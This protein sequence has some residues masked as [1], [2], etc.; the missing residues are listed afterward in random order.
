MVT[1]GDGMTDPTND[2]T[3]SGTGGIFDGDSKP[4]IP[5]TTPSII[6]KQLKKI[7]QSENQITLKLAAMQ[8]KQSFEEKNLLSNF[9]SYLF[10]NILED[11]EK[12]E[13]SLSIFIEIKKW[14]KP[15]DQI[16][17]KGPDHA[18]K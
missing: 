16:G 17:F 13:E 3:A 8:E 11:C 18:N 1:L 12:W 7:K 5:P 10:F 4:K 14:R 6:Q 15:L 2:R 9:L